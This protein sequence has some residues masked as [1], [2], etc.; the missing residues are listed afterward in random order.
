VSWYLAV[1]LLRRARIP[2]RRFVDG[3]PEE[4]AARVG[5]AEEAAR[6]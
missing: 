5:V 2:F 4:I 3:W 6:T 1:I